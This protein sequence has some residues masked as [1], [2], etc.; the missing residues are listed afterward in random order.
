[1][2]PFLFTYTLG[3]DALKPSTARTIPNPSRKEPTKAPSTYAPGDNGNL[4]DCPEPTK[5]IPVFAESAKIVI[6]SVVP[7]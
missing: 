6:S 7:A 2:I 1:M 5:T 3:K 4:I